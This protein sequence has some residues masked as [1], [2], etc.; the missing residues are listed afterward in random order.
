MTSCLSVTLQINRIMTMTSTDAPKGS[1]STS[2]SYVTTSN[3]TTMMT[4]SARTTKR[5]DGHWR[6]IALAPHDA[7]RVNTLACSHVAIRSNCI[8]WRTNYT[9]HWYGHCYLDT[10][11]SRHQG[12]FMKWVGM[13]AERTRSKSEVW[14]AQPRKQVGEASL[15]I[16]PL[17]PRCSYESNSKTRK[18]CYSK[19]DRAM[20]AI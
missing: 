8:D 11:H 9:N 15:D 20:R 19:D 14:C 18:L 1:T 2:Q 13:K 16:P 10:A 6:L 7:S 12:T 3:L 4:T 17:S 5:G